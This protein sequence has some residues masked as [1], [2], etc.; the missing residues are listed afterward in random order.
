VS[1]DVQDQVFAGFGTTCPARSKG[2]VAGQAQSRSTGRCGAIEVCTTALCRHLSLITFDDQSPA[3]RGY[4]GQVTR[5]G[6]DNMTGIGAP[7]GQTFI[8]GLRRLEG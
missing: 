5:K 3:M 7:R 2:W 6:Y 1:A 8:N 4:T